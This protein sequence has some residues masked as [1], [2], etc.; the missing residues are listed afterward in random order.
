LD[1]A[2]SPEELNQPGY[3]FHNLKGSLKG[4]YAVK[5]SGNGR[6]TF[7]FEDEDAADVNYL[8]YH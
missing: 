2:K 8:D 6:I 5:V 1:A 7:R 4:F 3:N